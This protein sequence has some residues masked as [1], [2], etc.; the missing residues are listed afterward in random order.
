MDAG[1]A[2]RATEDEAGSCWEHAAPV[3]HPTL[4]VDESDERPVNGRSVKR[5]DGAGTVHQQHV[6]IMSFSF[7]CILGITVSALFFL[8]FWR[9]EIMK[10][11]NWACG[12]GHPKENLAG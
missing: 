3:D 4:M 2:G 5:R 12:N 6:G 7:V 8:C 1:A 11:C 10:T 9:R